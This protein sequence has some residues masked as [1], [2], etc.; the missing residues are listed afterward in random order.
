ML[1]S[2]S[3]AGVGFLKGWEELC[4]F[5]YPDPASDLAKASQS[6]RRRWGH[7]P[8]PEILQSLPEAVRALDG[9]PWTIAY[10]HTGGVRMNQAVTEQEAERLLLA[11]V[12][13]VEVAVN[14]LGLELTQNQFDA[15]VSA[16]FNLGTGV[17]QSHRSL[18]QA[19]RGI[20]G[21]SVPEA[22]AL[23][24]HAGPHRVEGLTRRRAAEGRLWATPDGE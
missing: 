3:P 13:P 14:A 21:L 12:S 20:G 4:L 2:L 15:L 18:G 24:D 10:G 5:A 7:E 22:L 11:D 1:R 19:L 16:G 8:A 17:F 6:V 23:Y 9:A